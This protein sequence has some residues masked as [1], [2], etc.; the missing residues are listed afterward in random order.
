MSLW[1]VLLLLSYSQLYI[2]MPL[3]RQFIRA[4]IREIRQGVVRLVVVYSF[5][6]LYEFEDVFIE[7]SIA[8]AIKKLAQERCHGKLQ[9][10]NAAGVVQE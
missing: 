1:L 8:D 6:N 4:D 3:A 5:Y 7:S 10:I 9:I 2:V